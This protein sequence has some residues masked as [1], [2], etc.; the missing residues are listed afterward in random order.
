[1]ITYKN[2]DILLSDCDALCHQVNSKGVMGAGLA[3]Q[4]RTNFPG[5]YREYLLH[6]KRYSPSSLLGTIQVLQNPK[7]NGQYIVNIFGQNDFGYDKTYTD[8]N[9][10]R[11]CFRYVNSLFKGKT[12]AIPYKIG[13]GY[14]GGDWDIV[15]KI[16][17]EECTDCNT[18]IYKFGGTNAKNSY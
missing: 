5:V 2:G 1:M 8:Y 13:C 14:G 12:V 3:K 17:T 18:V 6:C 15:L 4:I 11:S 7:R 10:L 9:A 16:I